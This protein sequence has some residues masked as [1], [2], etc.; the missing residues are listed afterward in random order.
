MR[1]AGRFEVAGEDTLFLDEVD[2]IPLERIGLSPTLAVASASTAKTEDL[3][4]VRRVI[5]VYIVPMGFANAF[6]IE[7]DDG[8]C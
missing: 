7:G 4:A 2:D 6:L 3:L 8:W 5:G 1:K